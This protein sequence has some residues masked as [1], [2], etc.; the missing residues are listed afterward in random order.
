[1]K[2]K[3]VIE[4]VVECDDAAE[5]ERMVDHMLDR[6]QIQDMLAEQYEDVLGG[7]LEF[8]ESSVRAEEIAP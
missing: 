5:T 6:G 3:I 8:V 2:T 7:E 1:M 4:L